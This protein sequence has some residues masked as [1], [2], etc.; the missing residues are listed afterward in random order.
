MSSTARRLKGKRMDS[1]THWVMISG[2][3]RCRRYGD[4]AVA[5]GQTSP[6]AVLPRLLILP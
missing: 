6:Y 3:N 2:G 5:M 1:S 4:A